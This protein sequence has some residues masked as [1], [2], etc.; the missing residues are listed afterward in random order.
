MI[1][2]LSM[3]KAEENALKRILANS[4]NRDYRTKLLTRLK[5]V[6]NEI[7]EIKE[8]LR[9]EKVEKNEKKSR[10]DI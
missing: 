6:Q 7:K 2:K 5:E 9:K 3:L 8:D 1:D 10:K 4:Y